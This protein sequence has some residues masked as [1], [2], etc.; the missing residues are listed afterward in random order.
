MTESL[1]A[2]KMLLTIGQDQ[3]NQGGKFENI[4]SNNDRDSVIHF[5]YTNNINDSTA[6]VTLKDIDEEIKNKQLNGSNKNDHLSH[7][8]WEMVV[9][10]RK[11]G[12]SDDNNENRRGQTQFVNNFG[13]EESGV[14]DNNFKIIHPDLLVERKEHSTELSDAK[15]DFNDYRDVFMEKIDMCGAYLKTCSSGVIRLKGLI[16]KDL[17]NLSLVV[18]EPEIW[19]RLEEDSVEKSY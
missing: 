5:N 1:A 19:R 16:V 8:N 18:H 3:E 14:K 6:S 10:E 4:K 2:V 7:E 13:K 15:T 17:L 12:D 9:E 11:D